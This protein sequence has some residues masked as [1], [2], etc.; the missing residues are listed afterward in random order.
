MGTIRQA[1]DCAGKCHPPLFLY[2]HLQKLGFSWP[3]LFVRIILA[4][5]PNPR[6][7][8]TKSRANTDIPQFLLEEVINDKELHWKTD[9]QT[10]WREATTKIFIDRCRILRDWCKKEGVHSWYGH[11]MREATVKLQNLNKDLEIF[12]A[13]GTEKVFGPQ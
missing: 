2:F 3:L 5:R 13:Q 12:S 9:H 1:S 6:S 4:P 11:S 7:K 10:F 8:S